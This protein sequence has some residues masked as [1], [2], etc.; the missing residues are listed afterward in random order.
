VRLERHA[1]VREERS[2]TGSPG[3]VR[4]RQV[5]YHAARLTRDGRTVLVLSPSSFS[6]R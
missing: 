3:E 2:A 5:L 1:A 6:P 4:I